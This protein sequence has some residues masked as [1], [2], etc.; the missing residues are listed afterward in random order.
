MK[1]KYANK[2][3][4]LSKRKP[5]SEN[6]KTVL[7]VIALFAAYAL[8]GTMDFNDAVAHEAEQRPACKS[9]Y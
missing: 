3:R 6:A 2:T 5:L 8:V 4:M 1:M 9:G 7:A